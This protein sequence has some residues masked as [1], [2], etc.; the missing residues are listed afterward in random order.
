MNVKLRVL[1]AGAVFFLGAQSVVAQKTKNDTVKTKD[2]EEVVMV[3]YRK[4]D[5]A[6][7]AQA[8]STITAKDLAKQS[9]TLSMSNMLQGKATGVLVQTSSGKPGDTGNISIR[10]VGNLSNTPPLIV[11]D[12]N[13]VSLAQYNAL[14]P[15]EVESQVILKDAAATAQY[16][17]R[18]ANGVIVVTTKLGK[19][20]T[21][22]SFTTKIGTAHKISDKELNFE[23]MNSSQ[24]VDYENALAPYISNSQNYL[25]L[26][27]TEAEAKAINTNWEDEILRSSFISSYLLNASGGNDK[28]RFFYSLG[29]DED[30]GIVKYLDGLKRYTGRFNF[31]NKLSDKLKVGVNSSVQYQEVANQRDRYNAQNPFV[32]AYQA[33][34]YEKVFDSDGSYNPTTVG[35]PILEA[36]QTNT[37]VGSNLRINGVAFAE[38]QIL[39]GLT[40]RSQFAATYND[41]NRKN[42]TKKDSYL[43]QILKLGGAMNQRKTNWFNYTFLNR[44]DYTKSFGL[45]NINA[46]AFYEFNS[47]HMTDLYA[48]GKGYKTDIF[49]YLD[50][51]NTPTAIGGSREEERRLGM[52]LLV[53]YS[54]DKKYILTGAIRQD[55]SSRFGLNNQKGVFWSGSAAWNVARESFMDNT[56]FNSLKLRASYG[57]SGNDASLGNY[58]NK[59][60]VAFGRYGQASTTYITTTLGNPDL[61][62]EKV[63]ITNLGLD[64][65]IYKDRISGAVEVFRN[66]RSDFIQLVN[67]PNGYRRYENTGELVNEGIEIALALDVI[68]KKGFNWSI[69]LNTSAVKNKLNRL[70]TDDE[71]ERIVGNN[72]L[73]VGET[74]YLF[75]LVRNAGVDPETGDML[76]YTNRDVNDKVSASEVIK[77]TENGR[78]TNVYSSRDRQVIEGKSPAPKW[79]GGFGT[80][81]SYKGFDLSADFVYKLGGYTYN[82]QALDRLD[83]AQ[84]NSNKA[85]EAINFWRNK[86]DTNVLPKPTSDGLYGSDYFLQKSD[87]L[88][89]RSLNLGYTF[90]KKNWGEA[91]PL[92]SVRVFVQGQNLVT[93]TKFQGDPEVSIGSGE[94]KTPFIPNAYTLY[95]YPTTKIYTFGVEINF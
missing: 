1:T 25:A 69:N 59:S 76:Y 95:T 57:I 31:E 42:I 64:F 33:N 19:G 38:Y 91:L 52:A 14:S 44:L 30:T 37:S 13:Y 43:D 65:G 27:L 79:F 49:D 12:G 40:F 39:E 51:M 82:N 23:M 11:I 80:S 92:S 5:K 36:L 46:T 54:Y 83:P 63:N 66:K 7:I 81:I 93:W 58:Q 50:N 9:P 84:Y 87:Y 53:D 17:S 77:D 26:G 16:G 55:G 72:I 24:K 6:D 61:K 90:D 48:A 21:R 70:A 20:K 86:G 15:S 4:T 68:R 94:S 2:I 73:K 85:V 71:K 35:F 78:V 10:G 41:L 74:P 3:G 18:G 47:I 75:Y 89:L 60:Y 62:W 88:R 67:L 34:P 32:F 56:P 29:Y 45:N 28:N 8:V 22:Y